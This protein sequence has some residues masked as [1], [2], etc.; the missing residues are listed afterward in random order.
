MIAYV[1]DQFPWVAF[2][3]FVLG[4]MVVLFA[5]CLFLNL[6]AAHREKHPP[7]PD[8]LPIMVIEAGQTIYLYPSQVRAGLA[9]KAVPEGQL[10]P[11]TGYPQWR[12]SEP[13]ADVLPWWWGPV[14][15]EVYGSAGYGGGGATVLPP[16]DHL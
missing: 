9:V 13:P 7:D 12:R 14:S 2:L 10:T 6:R 15:T 5:F 3:G 4:G 11:E 16:E 8:K 1:H